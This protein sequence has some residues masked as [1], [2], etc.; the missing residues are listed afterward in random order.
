MT[1]HAAKGLEAPVVI[2]PDT[3]TTPRHGR[4]DKD[5]LRRGRGAALEDRDEARRPGASQSA[6]RRHKKS[7]CAN[8]GGLLYVALTR[9]RDRLYV[10]GYEGRDGRERGCW[11]DLVS[12]AMTRLDC[13]PS[14]SMRR[15]MCCSALARSPLVEAARARIR[16]LPL[17]SPRF[18][19]WVRTAAPRRTRRSSTSSRRSCCLPMRRRG[20][21]DAAAARSRPRDPPRVGAACVRAG[22]TVE[23]RSRAGGA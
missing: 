22:G 23:R 11:F 7:G 10:C 21:G 9:A 20:D 6:R 19:A 4:H 13:G 5:L 17:R 3:C 12:A 18:P 8:T 2:L 16:L 14:R 15:A 1:V